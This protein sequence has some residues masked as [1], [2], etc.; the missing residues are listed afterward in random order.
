MYVEKWNGSSDKIYQQQAVPDILSGL[1]SPTSHQWSWAFD[2]RQPYGYLSK[3]GSD[4]EREW[5]LRLHFAQHTV[6]C[7]RVLAL[8]EQTGCLQE[9]VCLLVCDEETCRSPH[10][11]CTVYLKLVLTNSLKMVFGWEDETRISLLGG[12]GKTFNHVNDSSNTEYV[13]NI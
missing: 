9:C 13:S 2:Q 3:H 6:T 5:S 1:N 7:I 8:I 11:N 10:R 4:C 12:E